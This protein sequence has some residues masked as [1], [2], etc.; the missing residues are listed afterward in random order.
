MQ[1]T[2]ASRFAE[3]LAGALAL[4]AEDRVRL[5]S[6]LERLTELSPSPAQGMSSAN[7]HTTEPGLPSEEALEPWLAQIARQPAWNQLL[8]L[9]DALENVY[10]EGEAS[11]LQAARTR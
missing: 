9:D 6:V 3:V 10:A 2:S 11:A 5:C 1:A 8:L 7:E 4:P